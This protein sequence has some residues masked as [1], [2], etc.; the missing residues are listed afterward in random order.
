MLEIIDETWI[1]DKFYLYWD[2]AKCLTLISFF[3][4]IMVLKKSK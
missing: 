1:R 3:N 4:D 2:F